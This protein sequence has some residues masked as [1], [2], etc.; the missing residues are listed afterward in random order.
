MSSSTHPIIIYDSDVEDA[1][2]LTYIPYYT[3]ASPNYSP[4]LSGKTCSDPSKNLTQN[5]LPALAISP[6]YDGPYMNAMQEYNAKLPI[7]AP[8]ALPP[9]PVL[10]PQFNSRTSFFLRKSCHLGND[11]HKTPLERHEEQIE[12]ILNHLDE[13]PL[14]QTKLEEARTQIVGLQKKQI[15]HDDEVVLARIRIS[16]VEMI[17]EDMH[18][19]HQ[20]DMK[21]LLD[22][23]HE[24]RT[25]REDH[26]TTRLDLCHLQL[27][28]ESSHW[29][30]APKR[31]STSIVP[32]M[33]QAAI[34]KL[35][36][37]SV[38][39]TLEAQA[40]NMANTDNTNRNT[41]PREI[42]NST[43]DCKVKFATGTLTN[44]ALSWWNSFAQPIRIEEAYKVTCIEGN[45][46]ASKSQ[47]LEEAITITQRR[48]FTNNN[49]YHNNRNNK[50]HSNDHHQ[51]QNRRQETVRAYAAT[52]TENHGYVGNFPCVEDVSYTI[53][54]LAQSSV[55][56]AIRWATR[57]RIVET[58]GQPPKAIYYQCQ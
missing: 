18:V 38:A 47:T 6:F 11:P 53:Q 30:M 28:L 50:N 51:Q 32:V 36:A 44:E 52:P 4:A 34:R 17:I 31:T 2:S 33:T 46:T 58:K 27:L 48:T 24:S 20:S 35:V 12:T 1:F 55:I 45:V 15:G 39:T 19:C 3:L 57:P 5:L 54:D 9:P 8:I 7:Q 13:L 42:L 29:I 26:Q 21:S 43:E 10:S 56:L 22:K 40:A 14:E 41:K 37:D 25:I 49:N 23:I 16:T